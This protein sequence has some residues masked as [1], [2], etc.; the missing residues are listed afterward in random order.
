MKPIINR[1]KFT[2]LALA[3]SAGHGLPGFS[4]VFGATAPRELDKFGGW[5]GKQFKPTGFFRVEKDERWWLVTPEGNA[6]LSF[7]ISH[8]E[9]NLFKEAY[10]REAWQER[11]G[12]ANAD[13][14]QTFA[15]A[16]RSW[17][18]EIC[19][20]YGF[21]TIGVHNSLQVVNRPVPAVPYMQPIH[22]IDIPLLTEEDCRE[23]PDVIGGAQRPSRIG[24]PRR[25]RNLGPDAPGKR[26]Y[27]ETMS[28]VYRDRIADFNTTYGM[29]FKTFDALAAAADWRLQTQLSNANETRDNIEFLHAVVDQYYRT[30]KEAIRRYDRNHLFVGDKLNGNTDSLDTVLPVTSKHTDVVLYQMY[31][32]YEVQRPGL[33]RWAKL[34]AQPLINGDAAFTMITDTMPRPYGPVADNL[35]QR[36]EWTLRNRNEERITMTRYLTAI[37]VVLVAGN[38][39]WTTTSAAESENRPESKP[40]VAESIAARLGRG[41][42]LDVSSPEEHSPVKMPYEPEQ[43]DAI[44]VAGFQ[45]VRFYVVVRRDPATYKAMIDDALSRQLAVM[46]SMWGDGGWAASPKEGLAEFV[47]AWDN[48]AMFYKDHSQ[49]LVLDLWNEPAGLLLKD[50]KPVGIKDDKTAMEYLN[51]AIPV[52]RKTNPNRILGIGSPGLNGCLELEQFVTPE[53]LTYKLEDGSGF[54]NDDGLIG[55]FHMYHPHAF[56]H[57]T[58]KLDALPRWKEEV[59][60]QLSHPVAW[61]KRWRKPVILDY[62]L[63]LIGGQL[64][65]LLR[66]HEAARIDSML[67]G[68]ELHS[69]ATNPEYQ[70]RWE[71]LIAGIRPLFSGRL[72]YNAGGLIGPWESSQEYL[73]VSFID[74]LDFIGISAYPRLPKELDADADD[75]LAGWRKSPYG[76]DLVAQLTAFIADQGKEVYLTELGSPANKGGIEYFNPGKPMSYDLEQHA[77]FYEVS[78]DVLAGVEKLQ[79]V[80]IYNWHANAGGKPGFHPETNPGAYVWNVFGKPAQNAIRREFLK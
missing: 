12:V 36:A 39:L 1:R 31:A 15:P 33:D 77:A 54:K 13:D 69:M 66:R 80:Y 70:L 60:E 46:I 65:S 56:T 61:S 41:I 22:F 74:S 59:R 50:G 53:H 57:W 62:H 7:G 29:R 73:N 27:V 6:F 24:F 9:S 20:D 68:N 72:G 58:Q 45:S 44:R 5:T 28:K 25:L 48:Y 75:Y 17:F 8:L 32:R 47:R 71:K 30:A 3:A 40:D 26:A 52:I 35:R 49:E 42:V 64:Q 4:R 14:W 63:Q 67:I 51:A 21:N 19:R 16:L 78:L 38:A 11:L 43:L 79:G 55:L 76:E 18:L 23:R 34:A 10:N 2:G 37:I